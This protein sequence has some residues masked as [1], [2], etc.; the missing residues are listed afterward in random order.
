[1]TTHVYFNGNRL[2]NSAYVVV[3]EDEI[4]FKF[5]TFGYAAVVIDVFNEDGRL[6]R[7]SELIFA[8]GIYENVPYKITESCTHETVLSTKKH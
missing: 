1:M 8:R 6:S 4:I 2:H 3:N 7:T 5:S